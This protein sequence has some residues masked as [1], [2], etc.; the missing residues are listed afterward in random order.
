VLSAPWPYSEPPAPGA[1]AIRN[2]PSPEGA[3]LGRELARLCDGA[4]S[5]ADAGARK[6]CDDCAFRLGTVPNQCPSTLMNAVKCM[7]ERDEFYCHKALDADGE[8][9]LVCA[10]YLLMTGAKP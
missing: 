6:R 8:P 10:G 5:L 7:A 3:E 1:P 2:I 9:K 4:E